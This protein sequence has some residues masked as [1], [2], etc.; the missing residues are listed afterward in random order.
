MEP[1]VITIPLAEYEAVAEELK[2][3]R[4]VETFQNL[5]LERA[6]EKINEL[7]KLKCPR[8]YEEPT[9]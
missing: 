6:R 4:A 5:L 8:T 2:R 7:K 9:T 3:L 1:E